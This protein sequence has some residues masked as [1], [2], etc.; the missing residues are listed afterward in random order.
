MSTNA[1]IPFDIQT[2]IAAA[3]YATV[4]NVRIVSISPAQSAMQLLWA[5]EGRRDIFLSHRL[6]LLPRH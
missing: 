3:V 1:A 4:G 6:V 5:R 2:A